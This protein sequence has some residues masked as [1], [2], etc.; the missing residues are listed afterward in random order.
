MQPELLVLLLDG[1]WSSGKLARVALRSLPVGVV[2]RERVPALPQHGLL[3]R[4][5]HVR[6]LALYVQRDLRGGRR[7]LSC[8]WA[9]AAAASRLCR[10]WAHGDLGRRRAL[11]G[12]EKPKDLETA[13]R[14]R[15]C[16]LK[17]SFSWWLL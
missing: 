7:E 13:C 9:P 16:T 1:T 12:S 3:L 17:M 11:G 6:G 2:R 5:P 4:L 14:S 15:V 10:R 8:A